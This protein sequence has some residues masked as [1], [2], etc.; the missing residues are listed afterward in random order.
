MVRKCKCCLLVGLCYYIILNASDP[1][2]GFISPQLSSLMVLNCFSI[3]Y[4]G[5]IVLSVRGGPAHTCRTSLC[6]S[7]SQ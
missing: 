6:T 2:L 4:Q 1:D 5:M 7:N 3:K